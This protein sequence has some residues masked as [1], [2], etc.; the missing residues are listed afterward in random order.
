MQ[1]PFPD[2]PSSAVVLDEGESHFSKIR[3]I[4]LPKAHGQS[5]RNKSIIPVERPKMAEYSALISKQ[6]S[7]TKQNRLKM[8]FYA[9]N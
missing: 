6:Q 7:S 8:M 5:K 2:T 3:S 9:G 4:V 1:L